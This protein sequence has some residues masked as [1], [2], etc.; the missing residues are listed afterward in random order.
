[1]LYR[2]WQLRWLRIAVLVSLGAALCW[3]MLW[4][5]FLLFVAPSMFGQ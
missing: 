1:M 5:I 4:V 2:L 3:A